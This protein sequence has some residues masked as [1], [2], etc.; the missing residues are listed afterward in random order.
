[1]REAVRQ[2]RAFSH[3]I[4]MGLFVLGIV[5]LHFTG[6][7][8]VQVTP[9]E[10]FGSYSDHMISAA[11]AVAVAGVGLL[12][13]GTG[14]ASYLIDERTSAET[15]EQLRRMALND[16]LTIY[17]VDATLASAFVARWCAATKI[18][19]TGGVLQVR[20]DEPT[21]RVGAGLY[22]AP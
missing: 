2:P 6:M 5:G 12:V 21:P 13:I 14:V 22:R 19:T 3:Y 4:A 11:I 17:F 15:V 10:D 1:M 9:I 18:E 8:A 20:E 7:A 16:A